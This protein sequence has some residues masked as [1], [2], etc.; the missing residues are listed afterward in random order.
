MIE[1][2]SSDYNNIKVYFSTCS[3]AE[4]VEKLYGNIHIKY[5]YLLERFQT[6]DKIKGSSDNR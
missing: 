4:R 6:Q 5:M 2:L 1:N 3:S